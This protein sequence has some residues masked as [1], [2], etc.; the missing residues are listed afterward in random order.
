MTLEVF[1][2]LAPDGDLAGTDHIF[3]GKPADLVSVAKV[4]DEA[5]AAN[6]RLRT[7]AAL[8]ARFHAGS[9]L[10]VPVVRLNKAEC[11]LLVESIDTFAGQKPKTTAARKLRE[12]LCVAIAVF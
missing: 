11:R 1:T 2:L 9:Q 3:T 6:K 8:A 4:L 12:F 7:V 10:P 5:H